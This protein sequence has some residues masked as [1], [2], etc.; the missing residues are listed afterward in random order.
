LRQ[1]KPLRA[2]AA[3]R[4]LLRHK[5]WH[6]LDLPFSPDGTAVRPLDPVNALTLIKAL[7][8]ALASNATDDVK[9]Y[10]LVW[11]IHLNGALAGP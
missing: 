3:Q 8:T 9:S 6:Y 1:S 5:Y 7:T 2:A 10:D 4:G 11:L